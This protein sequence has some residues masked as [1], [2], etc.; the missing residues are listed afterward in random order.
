MSTGLFK[1][2]RS[3]AGSGK[4]FTLVREYLRLSL[5]TNDPSS[6]RKILAV[7]FTNKAATE[8][9]ER[10]FRNLGGFARGE[11]DPYFDPDMFTQLERSLD[12]KQ[13]ELSERSKKVYEHMLHHYSDVS[14]STI[15]KFIHGVIRSFSHDLQLNPEF[16]VELD[17]K[18]LLKKT[19]EELLTLVGTDEKLSKLL[20]AFA[21]SRMEMESS[22]DVTRDLIKFSEHLQKEESIDHLNRLEELTAGD[23]SKIRT[24]IIEH[25]AKYQQAIDGLAIQAL[26]IIEKNG[27]QDDVYSHSDLPRFL[28]KL[29][30]K[31]EYKLGTRLEK[32]LAEGQ[33]KT[34]QKW[35]EQT[36]SAAEAA[37]EEILPLIR[38]IEQIHQEEVAQLILGQ[39]IEKSIY[40]LATLQKVESKLEEI[41][42]REGIVPIQEF[43][44]MVSDI[45]TS[46]PAPFIYERIGERYDHY[47]I[48]EFQDTSVLQWQNFLP[49][50]ENSLAKACFNMLVGDGKQAIYRWR[51]GEVEQFDRLPE[52]YKHKGKTFIKEKEQILRANYK[53]EVL[54][55]NFRSSKEVIRFNNEIFTFLSQSQ[56]EEEYR[57]IYE[58][59]EQKTHRKEEGYVQARLIKEE[60]N[61]EYKRLTLEYLLKS[62]QEARNDGYAYSDMAIICRKNGQA[63]EVAQYLIQNN[64]RVISSES[65]ILEQDPSVKVL[66]SSLKLIAQKDDNQA[67]IDLIKSYCMLHEQVEEIHKILWEC[68]HEEEVEG[69]KKKKVFFKAK[70]FFKREGLTE[71][72]E[73][74]EELGLYEKLE[75]L[76][77][78][79]Q[80]E[81]SSSMFIETLLEQAQQ[82]AIKK[83]NDTE[84]FLRWW[85][86]HSEKLSVNMMEGVN[87]V[88]ILTIHASKGLEYPVVLLPFLNWNSPHQHEAW[89][90]LKGEVPGLPTAL[91]SLNQSLLETEYADIYETDKNKRALDNL[92]LLYVAFTR[93]R[94]RLCLYLREVSSRGKAKEPS[95]MILDFLI[96][97]RKMSG[98]EWSCGTRA[99]YSSKNLDI[100][101]R[102]LNSLPSFAIRNQLK[103]SLEAPLE[104]HNELPLEARERGVLLHNIMNELG[105][106]QSCTEAVSSFIRDQKIREE[107]CTMIN[108]CKDIPK[109]SDWFLGDVEAL[110]ETS[111]MDSKGNVFRP[112]RVM[113]YED[114]LD[115]VDYKTG[116]PH[117]QYQQ[118]VQDYMMVLSEI[119]ERPVNGYLLYLESADLQKVTTSRLF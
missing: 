104:W 54:D 90:N 101:G 69:S 39:L 107:W 108:R 41:K 114:H 45:V 112:D 26:G 119:Y 23:Y 40:P 98:L 118:Q 116:Q 22:W 81:N 63:K 94:D 111:F 68:R 73:L 37:G 66:I 84:A 60:D 88:N 70:D 20:I 15:D 109:V 117:K 32:Q 29:I 105:K 56:L 30:E 43:N 17:T 42:E 95:K 97:K 19:V 34:A 4:T 11:E 85:D 49:L 99:K 55:H 57:G 100:E 31:G 61:D 8:M 18:E 33:F 65:L 80:L 110:N 102:T 53:A 113:I 96:N 82:F 6:Y 106:G 16:E 1:V 47:L 115:V 46:N 91:I 10:V 14:I 36:R 78:L 35:D 38:E 79:Y 59:H 9:K 75:R 28:R 74:S 21:K 71:F 76:I 51:G 77:R 2:Y 58:K 44:R 67:L 24:F 3:S 93:A 27:I 87:A 64:V 5:K 12:L 83:R 103:L 62:I 50:V 72:F 89:I 86:D 52:I 7:T 13:Q 25:R 92:N 48:D